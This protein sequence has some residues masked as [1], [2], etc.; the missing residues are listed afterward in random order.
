MFGL[1]RRRLPRLSDE[2]RDSI[3]ALWRTELLAADEEATWFLEAGDP[4]AS[5]V[6]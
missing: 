1:H 3:V 4:M 6:A 2:Q 5:P